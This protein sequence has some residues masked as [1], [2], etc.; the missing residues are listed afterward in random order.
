MPCGCQ[1]PL[2]LGRL[3][4][5]H[6]TQDYANITSISAKTM[7]SQ[8]L[9]AAPFHGFLAQVGGR[10]ALVVTVR[11][12]SAE[13]ALVLGFV[14]IKL[15]LGRSCSNRVETVEAD[16]VEGSV[17]VAAVSEFLRIAG[18]FFL[19]HRFRL[20]AHKTSTINFFAS[21]F[22]GMAICRQVAYKGHPTHQ[23]DRLERKDAGTVPRVG[24]RA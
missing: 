7:F 3:S 15:R 5:P 11:R 23:R 17:R 8:W 14:G 20:Y 4:S 2:R 22:G 6:L 19:S 12:G 18:Y 10:L 13:I 16:R 9:R 21:N 24:H 1:A